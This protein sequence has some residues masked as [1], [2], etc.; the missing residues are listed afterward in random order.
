MFFLMLLLV[1]LTACWAAFDSSKLIGSGVPKDELGKMGSAAWFFSC[2]LLWIVA[3]PYYLVK[4][5]SAMRATTAPTNPQ[6]TDS[7]PDAI[8]RL[9]QLRDSGALSED[10]FA[11]KKAELLKRM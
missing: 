9:S 10:E 4:R 6:T 2:L 1:F 11:Q 3:F 5:S 8:R 7:V